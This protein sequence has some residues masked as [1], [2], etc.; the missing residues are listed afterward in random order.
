M[1]TAMLGSSSW[2]PYAP[3]GVKG[4]DDDNDDKPQQC[5]PH[6]PAGWM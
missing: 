3:Q 2:M 4:F 6:L 5:S 1:E